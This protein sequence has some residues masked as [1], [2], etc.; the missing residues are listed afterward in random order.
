MSIAIPIGAKADEAS[1]KNVAEKVDKVFTELGGKIGNDLGSSIA[2]GLSASESKVRSSAHKMANSYDKVADSIGKT[3]TV[4]EQLNAAQGSGNTV[5][6]VRETERL[7]AARRKESQAIRQSINDL[8]DYEEQARRADSAFGSG[9]SSGFSRSRVGGY[10][11]DLKAEAQ[12][13]GSVA[14]VLAGRAMGAGITAGL[15]VATGGV[16]A[17]IG[18]I[19]YTLTK[20][21]ERYE[22]IDS[23]KHRLDNLNKTL[24]ATG[25]AQLDV[26]AVMDTVNDV[27]QGTPFSLDSAFSL[28]T[29]ALSSNTG[30]LKRFMTV[31]TDAAGFTGDGIDNIGDAFLQVANTGK[32]SMEQISNQLRN[33]P[34]LPWLQRQLG[35]TGAELQKLIHN[36]KVGLNDLMMAV[37]TNASGFAKS[38]GDS[39]EGSISNMQTAVARTGAKAL[40]AL[41]GQPTDDA[42]TLK[43]AV[44]ALTGRIDELG[45]WVDGHQ[46]DI[47]GFF[48]DGIS[49]AQSLA[50]AVGF[51][52]DHIQMVGVAAGGLAAAFVTWKAIEGVTALTKGLGAVDTLLS[53]TLPDSAASG[54]AKMTSALGPVAALLA[55]LEA[56]DWRDRLNPNDSRN[57]K[58][59]VKRG[60]WPHVLLGDAADWFGLG[61]GDPASAPPLA[62]V[63]GPG[64]TPAPSSPNFYKDWYPSITDGTT[65]ATGTAPAGAPILDAPGLS[66]DSG[67]KAPP[68]FDRSQ[69]GLDSIPVAGVGLPLSAPAQI[70]G[71]GPG[72][73]LAEVIAGMPGLGLG[74]LLGT[75]ARGAYQ[76]DPQ[77]V[78]D[79]ETAM[80]NARNRVEESRIRVLE[81]GQKE[82]VSQSALL[83]ARNNVLEAERALQSAQMKVLEAQQGTLKK[84]AGALAEFGAAIDQD[85]GISK[86]LPG[87]AENITKFIAN[88]AVAP[89]LGALSV[90]AGTGGGMQQG[91]AP[92]AIAG[93]GYPAAGLGSSLGSPGP[94]PGGVYGLP[95]GTSIGYGE[96]GFPDWV[97]QVANAFGLKA[98]TYGGH[99]ESSRGEAGFAPNPQGL[100]RGI[101]WSGPSENMQAFADYLKSVPGMEQVIYQNPATGQRTGIA[102]GQDV[103]SSG[104][105][106]GDYGG[107]RDHVHTRQSEAIPLP[108]AGGYGYGPSAASVIAGGPQ[109][110][111]GAALGGDGASL[112]GLVPGGGQG[113]APAGIAAGPGGVP[114]PG[115]VGVAGGGGPR[116]SGLAPTAV[117]PSTGA[118]GEGFQGMDGLP[119]DALMT[120]TSALDM[121]APGAS[122]A[123]QKGIQLINRAVGYG[124]QLV[125]IGVSGLMNAVSP[126]GSALGDMGNSWVGR[127]ASGFAGAR[128]AGQNMAG[129]STLPNPEDARKQAGKG[130]DAGATT[131]T[132]NTNITV[133]G[134]NMEDDKLAHEVALQNHALQ[135][136]ARSGR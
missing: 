27:V 73:S 99:Q 77:R 108:G 14:G 38:A 127:L 93:Y 88:I 94:R 132:T 105:Y 60:D 41:F 18:G 68:Q 111:I 19:G 100:N 102:G 110:P 9:F 112:P 107:H 25:K 121:L 36:N 56:V 113:L 61:K 6:I 75:A 115:I 125:G 129:Q 49:V 95:A 69:W 72:G 128:P 114:T 98:S 119:M 116:D 45:R 30:D 65:A 80:I 70:A 35:V 64:L 15:A 106:S 81:L 55:S 79:A 2:E 101:D 5:R 20:G 33:L 86:G 90:I 54:A 44:T 22:A 103:S 120:A 17:A 37:E 7:E 62:P 97:Y 78:F 50:G 83:S 134:R 57:I 51:V 1:W 26:K 122:I 29:R 85:F 74:G 135:Q 43:D 32:V 23:A 3:K 4:Q 96:K 52:G 124:G 71:G 16:A 40:G 53:K 130:G 31:V 63:L 118:G 89:A 24:A 28:S 76:V 39:L 48:E 133:E 46:D 66:G 8:R 10:F 42:N 117:A 58:D 136:H 59:Q 13:S 91:A 123:A 84:H 126:R 131:N 67:D 34:I 87:I 12:S 104:Y 11:S 47:R 82:N 92:A 109:L 21:F